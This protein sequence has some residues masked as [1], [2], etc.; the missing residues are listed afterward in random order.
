[1]DFLNPHSLECLFL[2]IIKFMD[3][4]FWEGLTKGKLD[5]IEDFLQPKIED[6]LKIKYWHEVKILRDF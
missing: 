2:K 6:F 4:I 3:S 1:M 5:I